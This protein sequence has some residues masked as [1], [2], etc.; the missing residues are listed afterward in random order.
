MDGQ[1][2]TSARIAALTKVHQVSIDMF[3]RQLKAFVSNKAVQVPDVSTFMVFPN[4][5]VS[6]PQVIQVKSEPT[7]L[8]DNLSVTIK[9]IKDLLPKAVTMPEKP[10]KPV[11]VKKPEES[12]KTKEVVESP[13]KDGTVGLPAPGETKEWIKAHEK[14]KQ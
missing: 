11:E 3:E 2:D 13:T 4:D 12:K 1:R 8:P 6:A 5:K 14:N 10:E 9:N 7:A